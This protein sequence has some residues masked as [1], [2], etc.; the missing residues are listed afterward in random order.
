MG[1]IDGGVST[2]YLQGEL[3][4][5]SSSIKSII[6]DV[7]ASDAELNANTAAIA[8]NTA[9]IATNTA[10]IATNTANIL[11]KVT[12][13][14][15]INGAFQINQGGYGS[16][17]VLVAAAYG[18]DQ[19]KAGASGGDYSFTQSAGSTTIT[20]AAGKS[21]IQPIEDV[22]VTGGGSYV[23][24][25]TGS[26]KA[27]VGVNT[28]TPTGSY[29]ASPLLITGQTDGTVMSV[30]FNSGTLVNVGLYAGSA[31]PAF[32][33]PDYASELAECLRY[34]QKYTLYTQ[35]VANAYSITF[36]PMRVAPTLTGG[37]AGFVANGVTVS[38]ATFWQTTANYQTIVLSGARL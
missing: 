14:Y 11:A 35:V 27:R 31:A 6:T 25:W 18:H 30:E 23:L 20:I 13:N 10:A 26:A 16:A 38:S 29:A 8:T 22:R 32:Q 37:A 3:A 19:W 24:A 2:K 33:V 9:A 21:L 36:P 4:S 15:I 17:A 7:K 5:I 28:L 1:T 12:K 34:Y